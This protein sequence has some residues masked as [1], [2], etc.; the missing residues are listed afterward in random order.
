MSRLYWFAV[1][2][3][4]S[5]TACALTESPTTP[6]TT[7][8]V[9]AS[10]PTTS[11]APPTAAPTTE[12]AQSG[13]MPT[14]SAKIQAGVKPALD[15]FL[16][17]LN[18]VDDNQL[19]AV[20]DQT[21]LSFKRAM[22]DFMH[23]PVYGWKGRSPRGTISKVQ[24]AKEPYVKVWL[25]ETIRGD[26]VWVFKW[27]GSGW[28]LS[29]P[30]E[31]ELGDLQNFESDDFTLRYYAWDAGLV[32]R[33]VKNVKIAYAEVKK[34]TGQ[35]AKSKFLVRMAPTFETD[36]GRT[37]IGVGATYISS[38][39]MISIPAPDSFHG[40]FSGTNID[41][42]SQTLQHE[43]THM[44]VDFTLAPRSTIWWVNEA[45]AHYFSNDLRP[46]T[47]HSALQ[48]KVYSLKDLNALETGSGI[49]QDDLYMRAE[50]TVAVQY[51]VEKLG[52]KDKA[53]Q[54]LVE[55]AQARDF[56]ASFQKVFG[57]S[58]DQFEKGWQDFMKQKYG[59]GL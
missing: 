9:P 55:E 19:A 29:E 57:M 44:M 2:L 36:A 31:D 17:A 13:A 45:F 51:M 24:V 40:S 48:N 11:V 22:N 3:L 42:L 37:P 7:N 38:N 15:K 34:N 52:G 23:S 35:Q 50:G 33:V 26:H 8:T 1:V 46:N 54:W 47:V 27:T 25:N 41:E 56:N 43:M 39:K 58:Y 5:L 10:A 14:D 21:N 4:L 30:Q 53:W 6:P 20:A 28:I 16:D 12:P 18:K 59:N 32:D 49:Q